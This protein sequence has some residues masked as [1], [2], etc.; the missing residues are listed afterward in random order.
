MEYEIDQTLLERLRSAQHALVLTGA[1]MSAESGIPTFRDAQT[2]IWARYRPEELA[3]PEAFAA[4]PGRVWRWYEERRE[5]VRQARPH[6]GHEALAALEHLI[7]SLTIA[8][9]NVDGLHQQAGSAR[10]IELHGNILRSKC[11][12]THR[13]ISSEWLKDVTGCPPP[14]PYNAK[15]LARPDVVWFGEVLPQDALDTAMAAARNCDICFSVGT[16]S[17]VQPAASLPLLAKQHGAILL[18][19]NPVDTALSAQADGRLRGPASSAL[20]A[21]L[22]QLRGT[23]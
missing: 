14:S 23:A 8:T 20:Q 10:V 18:E 1:G 21:V 19:I 22:Q 11:S 4:D 13:P 3:T 9:Q 5:K 12:V 7:P 16:T 2:G 17:L 15:G 6:A